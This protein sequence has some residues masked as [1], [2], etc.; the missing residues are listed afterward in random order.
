MH[1]HRPD[2][3]SPYFGAGWAEKEGQQQ[4]PQQAQKPGGGGRVGEVQGMREVYL[5]AVRKNKNNSLEAGVGMVDGGEWGV[6]AGASDSGGGGSGSGGGGEGSEDVCGGGPGFLLEQ[7][8]AQA[9]RGVVD[10]SIKQHELHKQ[11]RSEVVRLQKQL[12]K[13]NATEL[14][15]KQQHQNGV[16]GGGGNGGGGGTPRGS[17]ASDPRARAR[18]WAAGAAAAGVLTGSG[19]TAAAA[20]VA[21]GAVS[22]GGGGSFDPLSFS[23]ASSAAAAATATTESS[24]LPSS[25]SKQQQPLLPPS[26]VPPPPS[27]G[28]RPVASM[29]LNETHLDLVA[30]YFGNDATALDHLLG[31]GTNPPVPTAAAASN[32]PSSPVAASFSSSATHVAPGAGYRSP[33]GGGAALDPFHSHQ[34]HQQVLTPKR[35]DASPIRRSSSGSP[36]EASSYPTAAA[37]P[38]SRSSYSGA[39]SSGAAPSAVEEVERQ[40]QIQ[41][42]PRPITPQKERPA[43]GARGGVSTPGSVRSSCGGLGVDA[44]LDW[45]EA[46]GQEG[47]FSLGD[48]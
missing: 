34:T 19:A 17:G 2:L 46:L 31:D 40:Q 38:L 14:H 18:N 13:M 26:A 36:P 43:G 4:Q 5:S 20:A 45:A 15:P 28:S 32:V 21:V 9:S 1:Q 47:G 7:A 27:P 3:I 10:G 30:K 16:V 24:R 6:D 22:A 33:G 42:P 39:R 11:Q 44:L 37:A 8:M 35:L 48:F 25:A 12:T 29:A 23:S 41:F